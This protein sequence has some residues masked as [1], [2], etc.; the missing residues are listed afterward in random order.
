MK[1]IL[2]VFLSIAC[3]LSLLVIVPLSAT[4]DAT[5]PVG[6]SAA[7][8]KAKDGLTSLHDIKNGLIDGV[9]E[10]K[11]TDAEGLEKVAHIANGTNGETINNFSGYTLYLAKDI[12]LEGITHEPIGINVENG[13][14]G[15]SWM[16]AGEPNPSFRGTFDGQGHAIRNW[17][18]TGSA[19][20]PQYGLFGRLAVAEIRNLII[21]GSCVIDGN[22]GGGTQVGFISAYA[23]WGTVFTNISVRGSMNS[24]TSTY[25]G[26]YAGRVHGGGNI[27]FTNCDVTGT[28]SLTA[29]HVGGFIG[30]T[31]WEIGKGT[32]QFKSCRMAGTLTSNARLGGFVGLVTRLGTMIFN[33]SIVNGSVSGNATYTGGFVGDLQSGG[34]NLTFTE[35][36][37][38]GTSGN[39]PF[40]GFVT[41][42]L[43]EATSGLSI[44]GT[45]YA[46]PIAANTAG[47]SFGSFSTGD[48]PTIPAA[49]ADFQ[50]D[51]V[52]YAVYLIEKK[53][54]LD[55]LNDVKNGLIDGVKVYKITDAEGLEKVAHIANGTN[56]ETLN[57]FNGYVLYLAND[58]DMTGVTH[59]P[60]GATVS[61][62][63]YGKAWVS[64]GEQNPS[65]RGTFDGQGH[66]IV[67]WVVNDNGTVY[68][69]V[70][71][72][73]QLAFATIRNL[74]I[75]QSCSITYTKDG[76]T[77]V[78]FLAAYAYGGA[79]ITNVSVRGT[80]VNAQCTY[81]GAMI[82][83]THGENGSIVFTNCDTFGSITHSG[84]GSHAG[85]FVG[86]TAWNW[87][88]GG[89]LQF[90]NCR[91][92]MD[93]TSGAYLGGFISIIGGCM[94]AS[95]T[96]CVNN[97]KITNT[98]ASNNSITGG[99][100]A[101]TQ[102]GGLNLVFT[103]CYNYGT[104]ASR[105]FVGQF[106]NALNEATSGL[107]INETVFELPIAAGTAGVNYGAFS[108]GDDPT[109][110]VGV[111]ALGTQTKINGDGTWA[112]RILSGL[113]SL[114]YDATGFEVTVTGAGLDEAKELDRRTTVVYTAIYEDVDGEP[115]A[116]DTVYFKTGYICALTITNISVENYGALTFTIK[117]YVE[118]DGVR[119]Y[120]T[121]FTA[122][123]H[124][125]VYVAQ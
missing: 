70:G 68:N 71:L 112:I 54:G 53:E 85:G 30:S 48:D 47:T 15:K 19:S 98:T 113:E 66:K 90:V 1:R 89:K 116:R 76:G 117:P 43:N 73:G 60:I 22:F 109:Y 35:C 74:I 72:F 97:G 67:N 32:L 119:T 57:N 123:Y 45:V 10:Y 83:R 18:M 96:N 94:N 62:G 59:E 33:N 110:P 28:M 26:A 63:V 103:D 39:R 25:V 58:I 17:T 11:I 7:L 3:V 31:H 49:E 124:G 87:K 4:A 120:A 75:D 79:T 118:L 114:D 34:L 121:S 52:G 37:N 99:F 44:N 50:P 64:T 102:S 88:L 105:P 38:Y 5:A 84:G 101:S 82:A 80:I 93:I 2:S 61:N 42:A 40:V 81:I 56:G 106:T 107:T 27:I 29:D 16:T 46:T 91:N 111:K 122:T 24:V 14:Y 86:S 51:P 77:Q 41:G 21:D 12:N 78:S 9:N 20:Y 65:F 6:Y 125:G 23:Y 8:V 13:V 69:Q 92:A 100:V 115:V 55:E 108:T 36:Y 95:F 104:S